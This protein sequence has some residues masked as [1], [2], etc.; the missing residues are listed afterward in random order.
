MCIIFITWYLQL[1][2]SPASISFSNLSKI[3]N[4]SVEVVKLYCDN[5]KTC[6]WWKY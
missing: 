4:Y 1:S 3:E 5:R 6:N 2:L